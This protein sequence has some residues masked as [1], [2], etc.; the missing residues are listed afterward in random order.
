MEYTYKYM[1]MQG[2]D[3]TVIAR[4]FIPFRFTDKN[5][6]LRK[7]IG[8]VD[9]GSDATLLPP[10]FKQFLQMQHKTNILARGTGGIT[11]IIS[12]KITIQIETE[13][14][15][16]PAHILDTE[17]IDAPILLGR[18]GFF[19]AF[20]ILFQQNAQTITLQSPEFC[21]DSP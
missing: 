15:L 4:P 19:D 7:M 2:P 5:G 3:R 17:D 10:K 1:K 8:L 18:E 20:D 21:K 6:I 11:K 16:L 14:I 13:T 9:S 12:T